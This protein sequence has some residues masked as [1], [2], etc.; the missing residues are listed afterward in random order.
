MERNASRPSKSE[1]VDEQCAE[2]LGPGRRLR[3]VWQ[4]GGWG[5]K[6]SAVRAGS[7]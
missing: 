7:I 4:E 2:A 1:A 5:V 3:V 6:K